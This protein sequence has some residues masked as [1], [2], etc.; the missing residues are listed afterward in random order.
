MSDLTF[1][2]A[3]TAPSV[4][5]TVTTVAPGDLSTVA[6]ARFQMR[7]TGE[8]AYRVD[9]AAVITASSTLSLSLRYDW[10]AGD[11]DTPGDYIM[12]WELVYSDGSVQHT[13]PEN[14]ITVDPT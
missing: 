10:A 4:Y 12:R 1:V 6:S 3:D 5:G 9:A 8:F 7:L 11:L 14:T 13:E 2:Q